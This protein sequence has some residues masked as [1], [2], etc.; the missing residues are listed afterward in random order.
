M[1]VFKCVTVLYLIVRLV[2][3]VMFDKNIN[4]Y[5]D[6]AVS[7]FMSHNI[8]TF[9]RGEFPQ[10]LVADSCLLIILIILSLW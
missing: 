5:Q 8:E 1:L 2:L 4:G 7:W 6:K 9:I 3:S 10:Y